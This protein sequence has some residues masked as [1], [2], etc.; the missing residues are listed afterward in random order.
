VLNDAV[1]LVPT[2]TGF[3]ELGT[4]DASVATERTN[5]SALPE[6]LASLLGAR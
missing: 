4:G 2:G 1:V 6:R 3:K 5:R